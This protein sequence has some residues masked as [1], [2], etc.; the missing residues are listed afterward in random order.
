MFTVNADRDQVER[1]LAP[2]GLSEP[3]REAPGQPGGEQAASDLK[4]GWK[5]ETAMFWILLTCLFCPARVE[6]YWDCVLLGRWQ[7]ADG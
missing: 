6:V 1:E 5:T 2:G 3:E 7:D 4:R